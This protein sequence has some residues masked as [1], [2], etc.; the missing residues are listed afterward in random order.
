[1]PQGEIP[2]TEGNPHRS[3][4]LLQSEEETETKTKTK[5]KT[6]TDDLSPLIRRTTQGLSSPIRTTITTTTIQRRRQFK[7]EDK[8]HDP[9]HPTSTSTSTSTNRSSA[10]CHVEFI[11]RYSIFCFLKR[12]RKHYKRSHRRV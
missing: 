8:D 7:V 4:C 6:K 11:L 2:L 10:T 5:T 12:K 3:C 1:V 9:I